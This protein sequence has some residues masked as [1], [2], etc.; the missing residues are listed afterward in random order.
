MFNQEREMDLASGMLEQGRKIGEA[1]LERG[2]DTVET[3]YD[4]RVGRGDKRS[5]ET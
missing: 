1:N 5:G 2:Y 3:E 4:G